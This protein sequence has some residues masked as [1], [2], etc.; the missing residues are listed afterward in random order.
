ME[1]I[2]GRYTP[3]K[4]GIAEVGLGLVHLLSFD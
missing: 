1:L 4:L 2:K 3:Q